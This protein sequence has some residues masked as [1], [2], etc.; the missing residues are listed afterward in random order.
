VP[1][2]SPRQMSS[3]VASIRLDKAISAILKE[4]GQRGDYSLCLCLLV[5]CGFAPVIQL[6]GIEC[7]GAGRA[8]IQSVCLKGIRHVTNKYHQSTPMCQVPGQRTLT[9]G[10]RCQKDTWGVR[11]ESATVQINVQYHVLTQAVDFTKTIIYVKSV[12]ARVG[13]SIVQESV[14]LSPR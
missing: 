6:Q 13:P 4:I 1:S 8:V 7:L 10:R 14:Y 12:W 3:Q 2:S 11:R 5:R 9:R